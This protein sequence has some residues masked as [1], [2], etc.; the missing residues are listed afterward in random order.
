MITPIKTD[1]GEVQPFEYFPESAIAAV[2]FGGAATVNSG[3]EISY[4]S[5]TTKPKYI[6]FAEVNPSVTEWPDTVAVIR[7]QKDVIYE[8]VLSAAAA[9]IKRGS[10]LKLNSEGTAF[11]LAGTGEDPVAECIGFEGTTAGSAIRVRF[12]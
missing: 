11:V 3:G 12:L 9:N 5:G 1:K 6:T 4:A 2:Y 7:V 10:G 8:S